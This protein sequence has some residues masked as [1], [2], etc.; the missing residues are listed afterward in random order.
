MSDNIPASAV[1]LKEGSKA[2]A[3]RPVQKYL[4]TFGYLE[5]DSNPFATDEVFMRRTSADHVLEEQPAATRG[6]LDSATIEALKQFQAV[7][8]IPATGEI[9]SETRE[10][11][12]AQRC[13]VPDTASALGEY[14]TG[15]GK[16]STNHL[17]Y[18]FQNYTDD[19][20]RGEIHWA[21]DH[22]FS[23]W[24]AETPLRFRRVADGT[25]GDI[26]IRFVTGDHG[27]GSAFDGPSGVLA[28][29]FLPVASE[30]IRG[31]S[32][33]DDAEA[34]VVAIPITSGIDLVTV[35]AHEFG[36]ALGLRHSSDSSALMA[37]FYR[38]WHRYLSS[39][40]IQGIQSLYGGPGRLENA[41][42]IHGNAAL[43]EHENAVDFERKYGFYNRIVGKANSTNWIHF[44]L[45]TPV[46]EDGRRLSLDR[47][48]LR[49]VTGS[50]ATL[51][52]VHIRDG[53]RVV[54][55]LNG[56]NRS[57]V[58]PFARFG[59]ASMPAVRW[60]VSVSL[61]FDFGS[62]TNGD[63]RVDL[64]SAGFDYK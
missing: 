47:F 51:R 17:T 3:V 58:M 43:I 34:W 36:H 31:D 39:D 60:G 41:T 64:I 24:S 15:A 21:I 14:V 49:A 6:E 28:H 42:W 45:P 29:A 18:S 25:S 62:G 57:G 37:P 33:F 20:T 1:G 54:A 22:A 48:M 55:L 5:S 52:D 19:L 27:D 63:R 35:A 13:G 9:D 8:G 4:E 53:E 46:I 59:V 11:M 7:A 2:K 61:G 16:W 32:H 40:D 30:P 44:A 12:N 50:K 38:G 10:A 56:V 23:L 26:V